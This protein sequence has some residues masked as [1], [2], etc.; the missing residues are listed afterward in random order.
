LVHFILNLPVL[1]EVII[2]VNVLPV[3]VQQRLYACYL[4]TAILCAVLWCI[5]WC[6]IVKPF[7][8]FR[9][10]LYVVC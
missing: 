8:Q 10:C 2:I 5:V 7:S 6:E 3:C 4:I 9:T 1:A